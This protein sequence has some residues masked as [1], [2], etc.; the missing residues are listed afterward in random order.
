MKI[1]LGA[2]TLAESAM[3]VFSPSQWLEKLPGG[4][5]SNF[6]KSRVNNFASGT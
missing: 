1:N 3:V 4:N 6:G 2:K 5:T